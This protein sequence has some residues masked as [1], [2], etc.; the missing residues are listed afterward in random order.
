VLIG[1]SWRGVGVGI[2]IGF[3]SGGGVVGYWNAGSADG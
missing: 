3:C 2:L 1:G